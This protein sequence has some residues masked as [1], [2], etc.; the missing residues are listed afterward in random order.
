MQNGEPLFVKTPHAVKFTNRSRIVVIS[1]M[2]DL[3]SR[4]VKTKTT[5]RCFMNVRSHLRFIPSPSLLFF[6]SFLFC[7]IW[8]IW[9]EL[10]SHCPKMV[11]LWSLCL[12][13]YVRNW[14]W[15]IHNSMKLPDNSRHT[16]PYFWFCL[17][18]SFLNYIHKNS[19][20]GLKWCIPRLS[21]V[22]AKFASNHSELEKTNLKLFKSFSPKKKKK[23]VN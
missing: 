2:R 7:L 3:L 23:L 17:F 1:K 18:C 19:K 8:L 9:Q 20:F 22:E 21:K 16:S 5:L 15:I 11:N 10:S 4:I 14:T 13:R 6:L 12:H